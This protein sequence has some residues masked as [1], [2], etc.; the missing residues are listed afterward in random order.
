MS[1]SVVFIDAGVGVSVQ[2]RGRTGYRAIGVPLA[3]AA[4]AQLLA[5]A[6]ALLGQSGELAALEV[7]LLGPTLRAE[8]EPVR[9]AVAG[10]FA[11]QLQREDGSLQAVAAW[12]SMTLKPG[13]SLRVGPCRSGIGYVALAGGVDVPRVLGSRSTYARAGLGGIDGRAPRVG[14][15]LR[16]AAAQGVQ[17]QARGPFQHTAGPLRVL[18]GPQDHHFDAE[19]WALFLGSDYRVT[20]EADR[21]GL[22]LEG[23]ALSHRADLGADIVSEAVLPGAVQVPGTGQPIVLGVDAQTIGGYAK[24]ATVIAADL[25][26]LAHARAGSVLRF[27]AVTREEALAARRAQADALRDWVRGIGPLRPTG[28]PEEAALHA[29]NLISGMIDARPDAP[30]TLPWD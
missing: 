21:M 14:D 23:P 22:R 7:A 5:C 3:G 9:L 6:N 17:R 1:G 2:D 28:V 11:A 18:P 16:C 15:R 4:D 8:G 27:E 30:D 29:G 12:C 13:E 19:V 24:I 20:R 10:D 25:P 26:R